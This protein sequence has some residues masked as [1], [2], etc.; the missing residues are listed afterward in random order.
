ML[1]KTFWIVF[2]LT[3]IVLLSAFFSTESFTSVCTDTLINCLE[4]TSSQNLFD[5]LWN[6]LE[7]VFQNLVCVFYQFRSVF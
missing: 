1:M 7:C 3:L 6:G 5:K 2:L 4:K